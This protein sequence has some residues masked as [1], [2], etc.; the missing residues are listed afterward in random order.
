MLSALNLRTNQLLFSNS[1]NA[2]QI[3]PLEN[4]SMSNSKT[5]QQTPPTPATSTVTFQSTPNSAVNSTRSSIEG[6]AS[7][8]LELSKEEV[9]ANNLTELFTKGFLAVLTSK[10][11]VLKEMRDCILQNDEQPCKEVNPYL[12]SYC[13][14]LHVCSGCVSVDERVAIPH[15]IQDSVLESLH[16]IHPGSSGMITLGQNALWPYMHREIF[17]KSAQ[18][19]ACTEIGKNL[20]P[21][22]PASK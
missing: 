22:I 9:F 19:K 10:D 18:C 8:N 17:N 20:K 3:Q 4:S 5:V 16:L 1:A 12:H 15:S 11:A 14:N 7:P 2:A 13:R 21:I 6:P